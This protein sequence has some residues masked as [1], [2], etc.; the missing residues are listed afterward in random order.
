MR[1]VL[2]TQN[3]GKVKELMAILADLKVEVLSLADLADIPEVK[4]DGKTFKENAVKKA[5]AICRHTQMIALADDSGL[6][7][8]YLNGAPGVYS[9]R[10]AGEGKKDLD[11]NIKLL[12]LLRD[13]PLQKRTARFKCVIAVATPSGELFT[14]D[15]VCEGVIGFEMVGEKGF[16]YDPLFYLP[17]YQKTFAQLEPE[18]KNQISHR[19]IALQKAKDIL[20]RLMEGV[21][22]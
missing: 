10:F 19:G 15:G 11:N 3:Q 2:A 13:V 16:G 8:D 21:E 1:V 22:A 6:E 18:I 20:G 17:Q 7:V 12:N 9:A 14:T 4:E 5:K